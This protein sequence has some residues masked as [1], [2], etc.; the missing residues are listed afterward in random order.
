MSEEKQRRLYAY[1]VNEADIY[2]GWDFESAVQAAMEDQMLP[3]EEYYESGEPLTDD[4]KMDEMDENE[5]LIGP[6]GVDT[7]TQK[8]CNGPMI[9]A[10][11]EF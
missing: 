3:R 11:T 9:V 8:N 4:M 10:S 2:C 7:Y 6:I 5:N 1:K